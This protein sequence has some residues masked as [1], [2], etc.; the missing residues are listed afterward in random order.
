MWQVGM[1]MVEVAGGESTG[2]SGQGG[3]EAGGFVRN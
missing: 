1:C 2:G 3:E